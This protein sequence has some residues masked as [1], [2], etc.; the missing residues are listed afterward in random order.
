MLSIYVVFLSLR[1][2]RGVARVKIEAGEGSVPATNELQTWDGVL[3]GQQRLRTMSCSDKIARWSVLGLQGSLLS[4]YIEPIYLKSLTV[5]NLF[6]NDHMTRALYTRMCNISG[7]PETYIVNYSL[8]L[9][10][11]KPPQRNVVKP[12]SLSLN[13]SWGDSTVEIINSR[14][15][16][17]E[18]KPSRISKT[19]LFGHFLSLWD[20]LSRNKDQVNPEGERISGKTAKELSSGYDYGQ[21]KGL[22]ASYSKAKSL[23]EDH[24]AKHLGSPWVK[25]PPEQNNFKLNPPSKL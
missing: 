14:T 3:A 9:G 2:S 7:L 5:G 13:W 17:A 6:S 20:A 4:H 11:S 25:K 19:S 1:Q 15:G 21:I 12:S 16:K 10:T 23:V 18:D 8:L 24:F 22:S